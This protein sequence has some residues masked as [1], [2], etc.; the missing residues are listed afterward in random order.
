MYN[1]LD[2]GFSFYIFYLL[3]AVSIRSNQM[4]MVVALTSFVMTFE[5]KNNL[6]NCWLTESK[7][8]IDNN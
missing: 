3:D 7:K 6:G 1:D 4:L 5:S 8:P 2:V